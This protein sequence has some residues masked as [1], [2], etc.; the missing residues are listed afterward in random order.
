MSVEMTI[1]ARLRRRARHWLLRRESRRYYA[2]IR[3][4]YTGRRGFVIGNGPSLKVA[5][6]TRLKDEI[7]IASNKIFLAFPETP[8]RPTLHTMIDPLVIQKIGHEIGRHVAL[9]HVPE[10]CAEKV[11]GCRKITHWY[12]G[13]IAARPGREPQFIPDMATGLYCGATVTYDNLQ[14]AVH[15]GLN[16]IYLLGCD[17]FYAGEKDIKPNVAIEAAEAQNHFIKGYRQPGELV[18][19]APIWLMTAAYEH[20]RVYADQHGIR[21]LNATRGGH[22]EVFERVELDTLV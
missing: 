10:F 13:E 5:D 9:T 18:N 16:P 20:A 21:I 1:A 3:G 2:S 12:R 8:W 22:L 11:S 14:L 6:L 15:L 4:R 19:P 17:H 7:T